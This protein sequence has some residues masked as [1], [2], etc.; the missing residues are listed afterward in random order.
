MELFAPELLD[1]NR[2][3]VIKKRKEKGAVNAKKMQH[4]NKRGEEA[5]GGRQEELIRRLAGFLHSTW[6]PLQRSLARGELDERLRL[7]GS[8]TSAKSAAR[9]RSSERKKKKK[10]HAAEI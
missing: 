8:G 1:R 3:T 4:F 9:R 6:A 2:N 5:E 7:E 10:R